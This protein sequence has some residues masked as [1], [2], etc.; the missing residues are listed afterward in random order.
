[1]PTTT[2]SQM[3]LFERPTRSME[4]AMALL[5]FRCAD[6]IMMGRTTALA[7]CQKNGHVTSLEVTRTMR[8]TGLVDSADRC[9]WVGAVFRHSRFAWTG[10]YQTYS[11]SQ[12]NVHERT[13]K[14]WKLRV[15]ETLATGDKGG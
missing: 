6:R 11:D 13:V 5:N 4:E 8:E 9:H 14:V 7:L 12:R 2:A 1:M 10:A 15:V 3:P